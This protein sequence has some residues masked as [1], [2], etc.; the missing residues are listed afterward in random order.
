MYLGVGDGQGAV[1]GLQLFKAWIIRMTTSLH[2]DCSLLE[3]LCLL[4]GPHHGDWQQSIGA[5][6]HDALA[7]H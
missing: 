4:S 5:L 3:C 7:V 6:S 1:S 2:L